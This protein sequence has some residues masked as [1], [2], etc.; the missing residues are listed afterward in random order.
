MRAVTASSPGG[1][2]VLQL[3]DVPEPDLGPGEVLIEV[4]ATAINRADL[5]Q[6]AGHYPPP[7]DA[8][9]V[10]GLE[11][12]GT[13]AAV[14]TDVTDWKIGDE[15]CAL[16]TAGG[17]AERVA[18]PATQVLP[19]PAGISLAHAAALPEAAGTVWSTVFGGARLAPGERLLVHGG[20]G[21]IGTFAIQLA[22][23]YGA[24]VYSTASAGKLSLC[25]ALGA[26]AIDYAA[27]DF[28]SVL[29]A[30]G[31]ADVILDVVGAGYLERNLQA[32]ARNG[33]LVVIGLQQGRRGELDLGALLAR[34]ATIMGATLR[35]R[36]DAEKATI[37]AEVRE[38][39][40][41]LVAAGT[42]RPII[43]RAFALSDVGEAHSYMEQGAH[44]G[45]VLLVR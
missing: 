11:C 10:L 38:H 9:D 36:P 12:S 25:R 13:I 22:A 30:V 26:V 35:S 23:A 15:V 7:P 14:G 40:W 21:G 33:R 1:P 27:D 34:N 45:K 20:S 31:G 29:R 24:T 37:V 17:Y 5:L 42:V 43:D 4:V 3:V 8:S 39:V 6:R 2:E 16:L 19:V 32:L 18:V 28:V 41:P 44:A